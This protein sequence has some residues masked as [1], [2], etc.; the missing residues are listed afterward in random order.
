METNGLMAM[1]YELKTALAADIRVQNL[2]EFEAELDANQD[3]RALVA[4]MRNKAE[5]Y[6]AAS[7]GAGQTLAQQ[8]LHLAKKALD[9]HPLVRRYNK[10]YQEV[11]LMYEQIQTTLFTPFNLHFCGDAAR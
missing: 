6:A 7:E 11:R 2:A 3:V 4:V 5:T 10:R 1:A 9:E 8:E